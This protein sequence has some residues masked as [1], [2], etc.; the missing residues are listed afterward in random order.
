[1]SVKHLSRIELHTSDPALSPHPSRLRAFGVSL[2]APHP[3][4][5]VAHS[6]RHRYLPAWAVGFFYRRVLLPALA[7]RMGPDA[8]RGDPPTA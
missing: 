2:V 3:R 4:A 5:R 7:A 8:L 6:E 1:M